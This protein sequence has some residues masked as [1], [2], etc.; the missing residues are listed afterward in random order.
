MLV[1]L[2]KTRVNVTVFGMGEMVLLM[3]MFRCPS[4][5]MVRDMLSDPLIKLVSWTVAV[6][7]LA[8]A[9]NSTL[10]AM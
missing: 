5:S 10:G 3:K 8:G 1:D 9:P 4:R 7:T 2:S 6:R